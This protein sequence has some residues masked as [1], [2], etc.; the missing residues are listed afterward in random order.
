M[1]WSVAEVCDTVLP[2]NAGNPVSVLF[3]ENGLPLVSRGSPLSV[4]RRE[5]AV[6]AGIERF[7]SSGRAAS[8]STVA[9]ALR[10]ERDRLFADMELGAGWELSGWLTALTDATV[11]CLM[12]WALEQAE[13]ASCPVA[14]VATGGYGRAELFPWSDVDLAVVPPG[15]DDT[16]LDAFVRALH[17]AAFD[18]FGDGVGLDVGY[19]FRPT[20]DL[21]SVDDKTLTSFL[22]ARLVCGSKAVFAEFRAALNDCLDP[23]RA[24]PA[25]VAERS[26]RGLDRTGRVYA[27]EAD[28]K[29]H[30][31][32]MRD[33][34][35]ALWIARVALGSKAP[36]ALSDLRQVMPLPGERY[37]RAMAAV[38]GLTDLRFALHLCSG[39]KTDTLYTSRQE[40]VGTLLFEPGAPGVDAVLRLRFAAGCEI[41][42]L[43]QQAVEFFVSGRRRLG[44]GLMMTG[45]RIART[46]A[47][48]GRAASF[49][50]PEQAPEASL[51]GAGALRA[52][53][54]QARTGAPLT[55]A[56]RRDI[57]EAAARLTPRE[58][59]LGAPAVA[60]LLDSPSAATALRLLRD[61]G[62]LQRL[63]PEI[64]G[65][66]GATPYDPSHEFSICEHSLRVVDNLFELESDAADL[67][68]QL[69]RLWAGLSRDD[70]R[71]LV[72][73][74]FLHDMGKP[75]ARRDHSRAGAD[76]CGRV[77][78]RL[79]LS[80]ED[81]ELAAKLIELHLVMAHRSRTLDLDQEVTIRNFADVVGDLRTLNL[82]YLLTY[83]DTTAVGLGVFGD[84]ERRL[85]DDLYART[86]AAFA[87]EGMTDYDLRATAERITARAIAELRVAGVSDD[88]IREH[89]EEMPPFYVV[90]TP[91][92]LLGMHIAMV[93]DLVQRDE[94]VIDFYT[95]GGEKYTEL[96]IC[97]YDD[98]EP[99]LFSRIAAALLALGINLHS[100]QIRTRH[101][102][103]NVVLDALMV[104]F[105]GDAL[106]PDMQERTRTLL[107][108]V[109]LGRT[110]GE[111]L[112]IK[113]GRRL[114]ASAVINDL[115]AR[116]DMSDDH[117]V[118]WVTV[119]DKAGLLYRLT[120]ALSVCRLNLHTAKIT[121]W[122]GSAQ[123]VFYVTRAEGGKV[124]DEELESLRARL[125][126]AIQ[127]IPAAI[128]ETT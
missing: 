23:A 36:I 64:A 19:Q 59:T 58:A 29:A 69:M 65:T 97:C 54:L 117:T 106:T 20:S 75:L 48:P 30:P 116:N 121:S 34:C 11:A 46:V 98:P 102:R 50:A 105:R 108:D 90:S 122:G 2:P 16:A 115:L 56:L 124:S 63:L 61:L 6:A 52:L 113:R 103:R 14:L 78:E 99:G 55:A 27:L 9:A 80:A 4:D 119:E 128:R 7:T 67:P 18:C 74:A 126:E 70:R 5:S 38:S 101:G 83:A 118:V 73:A 77:G 1:L 57:A 47:A 95:K 127:D 42:A 49:V 104:D 81:T 13:L 110:S 92:P 68:P 25:L 72:L 84:I 21:P 31:G 71:V 62:L 53:R 15:P 40:A 123:N 28:L 109:L 24:L 100:A 17:K 35:F 3:A 76:I 111:E 120:R 51:D 79:R 39:R 37:A 96:T 107:A 12:N 45:G 94:P 82:L 88:R 89:C 93:R 32:G 41:S 60:E 85:L 10:L 87:E 8:P 33:L 112:L 26:T 125:R 114:P 86:V 91:L 66:I 44:N 22:D 43:A